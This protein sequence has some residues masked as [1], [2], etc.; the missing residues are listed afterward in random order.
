MKRLRFAPS[1]LISLATMLEERGINLFDDLKV[2]LNAWLAE[3][4]SAAWRMNSRFVVIVEMPIVSSRGE[5]RDGL[6]HRAFITAQTAG[7]IAV[8]LGLAARIR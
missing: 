8:A 2:R 5:Q 7:D 6:D 4:L 3:G 1:N